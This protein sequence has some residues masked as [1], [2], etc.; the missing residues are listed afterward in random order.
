MSRIIMENDSG[1]KLVCENFEYRTLGKVRFIG[2]DAWRTGENGMYSGHA[3]GEFMPVLDNL[4]SEYATEI[5]D[6]CS[7]MHHN[8]NRK[9][10]LSR[11]FFRSGNA[12][13]GAVPWRIRR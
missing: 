12:Y 9:P 13:T 2:I 4:M 7:R 3:G 6:D 1:V 10:L 8:G 5:T 11:A